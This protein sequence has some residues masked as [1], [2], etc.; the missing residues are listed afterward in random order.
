MG[1]SKILRL[2]N[3]PSDATSMPTDH[4]EGMSVKSFIC[5]LTLNISL[6]FAEHYPN[7]DWSHVL[8][9]EETK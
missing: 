7:F 4:L 6:E 9:S 2:V 5:Y 1:R 8:W 3:P